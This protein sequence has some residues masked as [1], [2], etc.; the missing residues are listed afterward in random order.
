MKS[1][2]WFERTMT[3]SGIAYSVVAVILAVWVSQTNAEGDVGYKL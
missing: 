2:I 1:L 3:F